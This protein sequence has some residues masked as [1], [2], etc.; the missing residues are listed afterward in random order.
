VDEGITWVKLKISDEDILIENI[1]IEPKSLAQDFVVYGSQDQNGV[2]IYVDF[3]ELHTR[4]CVGQDKPNTADSDYETWSPSDGRMAGKCLLGHTV[5]Y[6]RRKPEKQCFNSQKYERAENY[7]HCPCQASDFECD[8]GYERARTNGTI[9]GMMVYGGGECVK[10]TNLPPHEDPSKHI[11]GAKCYVR[12][13][14]GYRR[15]P[16][17]TC[18]GGSQWDPIEIPC[19]TGISH[20]A[21]EVFVCFCAVIIYFIYSFFYKQPKHGKPFYY[22]NDG[23]GCWDRIKEWIPKWKKK[24][25]ELL[26][27]HA[28]DDVAFFDHD[29]VGPAA[30]LIDSEAQR[31]AK[32]PFAGD[33]ES[34]EIN[35]KSTKTK[36]KNKNTKNSVQFKG[37]PTAKQSATNIRYPSILP[38]PSSSTV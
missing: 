9:P 21:M 8:Y 19:P 30:H 31:R 38:P 2:I 24:P 7:E 35:E 3:T 27:T 23:E 10:M 15:V 25:Y 13:T 16:G 29:E 5:T 1:I 12:Q 18:V 32:D 11:D 26:P 33:L 22:D 17:D 34:S 20:F 6:T 14:K 36:T 28:D 37:L 4:E